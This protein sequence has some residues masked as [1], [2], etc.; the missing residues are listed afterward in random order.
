MIYSSHKATQVTM[1]KPTI[2]QLE[3]HSVNGKTRRILQ[4]MR[5]VTEQVMTTKMGKLTAVS[6]KQEQD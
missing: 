1:A 4:V 3:Q 2:K 6:A 5:M